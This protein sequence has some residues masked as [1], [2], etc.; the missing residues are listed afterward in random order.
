MKYIDKISVKIIA[1]VLVGFL[2]AGAFTKITY[3]CTPID[4]ASGCISYDKAVMHS[5]DLI[6]NKQDSL[7]HFSTTFVITSVVIFALL[8]I[9]SMAQKR[10]PKLK[11]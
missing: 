9:L 10:K 7:V 1:A 2:L 3:T 4:S 6:S 5:S 11:L 8:S